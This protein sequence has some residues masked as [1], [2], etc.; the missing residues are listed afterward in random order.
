MILMLIM[1]AILFVGYMAASKRKKAEP[2]ALNLRLF[3]AGTLVNTLNGYTNAYT[4]A[5]QAYSGSDSLTPTL[6]EFY[7]TDLLDNARDQLIFAQLGKKQPLPA[8]TGLT[9]EWRKFNTLPLFDQLVDSVIPDG[10]K[11]GMTVMTVSIMEYGAFVPISQRLQTHALD[12]I[13]L[14]AN[15]ELGAAGGLTQDTLV[16]TVLMGA[17]NVIF[18]DA[19]NADGT[20]ASTPSTKAEL[21]TAIG[22]GKKANLT[23]D[24]IN[25]GVTNLKTLK[26]PPKAGNKYV[27]VVHPHVA[28]D[29]RKHP[30]W[31]EAHKYAR[32]EEI[33]NGEI[34]ELHGV[35]FIESGLAPVI[36]A[37]GDA[38]AT[39]KTMIFGRDAFAVIDPEDGGMETIIKSPEQVGGPLNQFSTVGAKFETAAKI[40]YQ[41]RMVTIWHG[42]SYS[43]TD[44][45]N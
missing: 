16:R 2:W 25:K 39:Y 13:I 22:A 11:L 20:Y 14:G 26:A 43:N 6:K 38:C 31:L 28:Y 34:G 12:D 33:F 15:E 21:I 3:D 40:L 18:A 1:A 7:D 5:N 24:M 41:D 35:R 4:G 8:H 37:S 42:S 19:Y 9:I 44:V 23:P 27:A 17:T 10:K 30:D 45:A 36:K 32:P 29:L